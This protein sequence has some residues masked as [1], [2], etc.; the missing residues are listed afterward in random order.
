V[1]R[2][3]PEISGSERLPRKYTGGWQ[4]R[5]IYKG[6]GIYVGVCGENSIGIEREKVDFKVQV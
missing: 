5:D 2:R 3:F 1:C 4:Y 6:W